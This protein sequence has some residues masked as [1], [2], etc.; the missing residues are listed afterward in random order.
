MSE[1]TKNAVVIE[2]TFEA[3]VDL[4]WKMWTEP[5]HFQQW[6]GPTGFTV[7]VADMELKVGGQRLI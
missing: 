3:S 2:R 5:E 4:L 6:Y 1:N 7:P